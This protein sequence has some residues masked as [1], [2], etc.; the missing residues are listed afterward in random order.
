MEI[1]ANGQVF[2]LVL[3]VLVAE[4][5]VLLFI[6][7]RPGYGGVMRRFLP[8]L[9]AAAGLVVAAFLALRAMPPP[10]IGAALLLA[11]GAHLFD[12]L[13]LR[14]PGRPVSSGSASSR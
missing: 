5:S 14:G 13:S 4:G 7:R 8:S 6:A 2:L 9:L 3:G 11:F 10:A 12:L 1:F